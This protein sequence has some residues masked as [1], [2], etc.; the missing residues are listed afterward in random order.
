MVN[1]FSVKKGTVPEPH[2]VSMEFGEGEINFPEDEEFAKK[3][4]LQ[5][6]EAVVRPLFDVELRQHLLPL[7]DIWHTPVRVEGNR[8][9][10]MLIAAGS[11]DPKDAREL[12]LRI[13]N[14]FTLSKWKR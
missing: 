6:K 5:G 4:V 9:T 7:A 12:I 11:T 1:P 3:Y 14:L 13:T 2:P 8:D 10:L